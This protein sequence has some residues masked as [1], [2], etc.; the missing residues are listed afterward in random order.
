MDS[1]ID[2]QR[3]GPE[4]EGQN[5]NTDRHRPKSDPSGISSLRSEPSFGSILFHP[6]PP[7]S[8]RELSKTNNFR[9]L[10]VTIPL[11]LKDD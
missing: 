4:V 6:D 2:L 1:S 9:G 3:R 7:C 8:P 5:S 10:S 11:N